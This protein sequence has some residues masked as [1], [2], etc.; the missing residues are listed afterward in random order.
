MVI[1]KALMRWHST[2]A[3]NYVITKVPLLGAKMEIHMAL[4]LINSTLDK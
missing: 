3:M 4:I 2:K 1:H